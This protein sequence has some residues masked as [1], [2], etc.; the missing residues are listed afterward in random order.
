MNFLKYFIPILLLSCTPNGTKSGGPLQWRKLSN[1]KLI[2]L[3]SSEKNVVGDVYVLEGENKDTSYKIVERR[4]N[5]EMAQKIYSGLHMT[6]THLFKP[7]VSPYKGFISQTVACDAEEKPLVEVSGSA[8]KIYKG[9][10]TYS[11]DRQVIE[12]CPNKNSEWTMLQAVVECS[13][14]QVLY[15]IKIY[16]HN[17]KFDH[18]REIFNAFSCS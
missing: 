8:D 13:V 12:T 3:T 15:E 18:L 11:G 1:S 5:H 2:S 17:K 16:S 6:I 10:L 4:G 14:S 9:F 7:Y